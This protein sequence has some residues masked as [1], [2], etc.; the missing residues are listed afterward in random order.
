MEEN[1]NNIPESVWAPGVPQNIKAEDVITLDELTKRGLYDNI[2]VY[3]R[4][5]ENENYV[6]VK[7]YSLK[8]L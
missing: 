4:G 7:I 8:E 1:K 6:P 5:S 3:R 2:N